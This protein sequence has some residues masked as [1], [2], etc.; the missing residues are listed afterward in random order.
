MHMGKRIVAIMLSILFCIAGTASAEVKDFHGTG[1]YTM[2]K[3]ETPAVA[4]E[5]AVQEAERD[6]LEQAGVY[7]ESYTKSPSSRTA[8]SKSRNVTSR[9][10][11]R[12]PEGFAS[13]QKSQH[14]LTRKTSI[15]I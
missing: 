11:R 6:A 13:R 9:R 7:V 1:E 12:R 3:Y 15:R 4:E 5:R 14:R 10:P 8:S 2:S